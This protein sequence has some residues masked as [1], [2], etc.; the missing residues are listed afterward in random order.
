[1]GFSQSAICSPDVNPA[2]TRGEKDLEWTFHNL[3]MRNEF[4]VD[5]H[6]NDDIPDE[7]DS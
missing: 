6:P 5:G 3:M 1:M 2:V 7:I 4:N